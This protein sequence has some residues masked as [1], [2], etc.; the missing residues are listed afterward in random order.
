M[1]GFPIRRSFMFMFYVLLW[2]VFYCMNFH[3]LIFLVDDILHLVIFNW[4]FIGWGKSGYFGSGKA[5][6]PEQF[7]RLGIRTQDLC[8]SQTEHSPCCGGCFIIKIT[9]AFVFQSFADIWT[10]YVR[11]PYLWCWYLVCPF[12]LPLVWNVVPY[13]RSNLKK[14]FFI[15]YKLTGCNHSERRRKNQFIIKTHP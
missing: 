9:F 3:W 4:I 13:M 8:R 12:D 5:N 14:I 11:S 6:S 10:M 15:C 1:G 2:R 7:D